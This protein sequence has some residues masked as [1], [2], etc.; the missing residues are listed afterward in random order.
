M[1][2]L[3]E[4]FVTSGTR[5]RP[6]DLLG[7]LERHLAESPD[8]DMSLTNF[9][10]FVEATLSKSSLFNDLAH[11]PVW[12]EVL[13][14]LFGSSQYFADILVRDPELFR[15]LTA[16]DVLE[17]FPTAD[18]LSQELERIH[19][20][21]GNPERRQNALRRLYR[22]EILRIG[23]RD[24]IG[25]A[26]LD[27]LTKAISTLAD[28]LINAVLGISAS[29]LEERFPRPPVSKFVVIGLG[30]LG[31]R[32]L[33]YSSDIDILFVYA[34]EEEIRD[35]DDRT[36][37]A[38]EYFNLLSERVVQNLSRSTSEGH[39]YRV[40]TRLRP[41]SGAGPLARSLASY[42]LYY[43]SRGE[44]WERQMLIKA[45][46]VA[47]DEQLGNEFIRQLQPFVY[48][49][50][51]FS[52]PGESIA[53]IKARIESSVADE[54]NIKLQAGGIR[55]IEFIVQALQLLNG[56]KN[57]AIRSGNTLES[58]ALLRR[59]DLVAE[60]EYRQLCDA[61]VFLR[62]MEH[63]LQIVLNTQTHTF[64]TDLPSQ[65]AL[66][67]RMRLSSVEDL[68]ERRS[69]HRKNVRTIFET[70]LTVQVK[71]EEAGIE[72]IIEGEAGDEAVSR[73]LRD[74]GFRDVRQA[75]R[76]LRML[77]SGSS[78]SG[79]RELDTR[80]R[81]AFRAISA[82]L[83]RDILRTA[84]PDRTLQN[85]TT[86]VGAQA[87]PHQMYAQLREGN[88]R[89]LVI[90]VAGMSP[91]FTKGLAAHPLLL[92]RLAVDPE[93]SS[94]REDED[95]GGEED[96]V[97]LK[98]NEELRAGIR[99]IL[100]MITLSDLMRELSDTAQRIVLRAFRLETDRLAMPVPPL[101]VFAMGKFGTGELTFDADLDLI[102]I[103][104]EGTAVHGDRLE[105]VARN[106]IGRLSAFTAG[107]KLYDVD[108]RLRP[109]GK[110]SPLVVEQS[111]YARY[112]KERASLWERQSLSRMRFCCGDEH[113]GRSVLQTVGQW[114]YESPLPPGWIDTVVAMRKKTETRSRA[115]T[116]D[117]YDIKLG[118][119]GMVDIEFLA[120][121][122]QLGFGRS[123][124]ELRSG[125]TPDVIEKAV[126]QDLI[127][128]SSISLMHAY[129]MYRKIET[130]IRISL[131]DRSTILPEGEKLDFLANVLSGWSGKQLLDY[132]DRTTR[133]VREVFLAVTRKLG[134]P[135]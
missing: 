74:R 31:G 105:N 48:P 77:V 51:F 1:A 13:I 44:M 82:D 22:R 54:D 39:L 83:L 52:H 42:V 32:E 56:G 69:I 106:I 9:V 8:P 19:R 6:E 57:E 55:D 102:F 64:P 68:H 28:A 107:G 66:A 20:T 100:G 23:T 91:R 86:L 25:N 65:Q 126:M 79:R 40:D 30:K 133:E 3:S 29:Q 130:F 49:K 81:T 128:D 98:T 75:S 113:L 129:S 122:L 131:E 132:V 101:A 110:N 73:F 108:V 84:S 125:K 43:E 103:A 117:F 60:D 10:R 14:T 127:P 104:G 34:E 27:D 50:T 38:H 94:W 88:F 114:V 45:R 7:L 47:G 93:M 90:S 62:T 70:V 78:L 12:S 96:L 4:E 87:F 67:Q 17:R 72:A 76:N 63:R 134:E 61:Y 18:A 92:D 2:K 121:I 71:P 118:P 112:L 36:V 41:E 37:T 97:F 111:S 5:V 123:R 120:Q 109:E 16:S 21:F 89:N 26:G 11:Y 135:R 85:L 115:R 24:V 124:N 59:A 15:W 80:A 95:P 58:L 35:R 116:Q 119:G 53:R 99:F 46:P 33:N